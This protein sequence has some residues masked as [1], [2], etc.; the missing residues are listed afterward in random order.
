MSKT[1]RSIQ[2]APSHSGT[3]DGMSGSQPPCGVQMPEQAPSFYLTNVD[4]DQWIACP[5]GV[6]SCHDALNCLATDVD[7]K[8]NARLVRK[9]RLWI[10]A[11]APNN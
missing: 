6:N 4:E 9:A 3:T 11:M 1:S 2:F 5:S 8:L 10:T 7:C